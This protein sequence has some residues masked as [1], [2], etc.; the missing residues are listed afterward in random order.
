M[1]EL[2]SLSAAS[3]R[4]NG[5]D[6]HR[7]YDFIVCGAGSAGSVVAG[8]LAENP[9]VSVLLIEAGGTDEVPEVTTPGQ[10]PANLG[11]ARDWAFSAEPNQHLNG[12]RMALNMGKLLGGSSS[13]NVGVWARGHKNDWEHFAEASGDPGWRYESVLDIYKRVEDW[14][15]VRDPERRG[16]GGPIY[17]SPA[18]DPQPVAIAMLEAARGLGIPTFDSPNGAMMEGRGGAAI[19]DLLVKDG[20]RS[21]VFRS[22]VRPRMGQANLTV[23]TDTLVSRLT[24][25]GDAV[26]GV[27]VI[28]N[29][30]VT[31][32]EARHEV[33]VSM[34]AVNTP[35]LLMQSGIGPED[36]LRRHGIDIVQHLAGV[37]QN[38]QDHVAFGCIFECKAPQAVNYGGSEATL[39]WTSDAA[40]TLPDI[41]HCQLEFP[42]PSAET[43]SSAVPVNG[44]TMFAGLAHP[45]SRGSLHLTGCD[46]RDRI[47]IVANTLSHPDDI[48]AAFTTLELARELGSDAA[49]KDLVKGEALPGNLS[50]AAMEDYLRNAAMTFWHQAGTAK[51]GRDEMSVVDGELK[52]YGVDHLRIADASVMPNV[53]SG[54]T[55]APCV[56][57]GERCA[58]MIRASHGI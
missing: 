42:V 44:W 55:M 7:S 47:R 9:Q 56:V 18:Q 29:G 27:E 39:Y 30:R 49:F 3:A 6:H 32:Y 52:V 45:K 50:R 13:I 26:R 28:R 41:F 19:T 31:R 23:L 34:G 58:D 40:Q 5:G 17:V 48:A 43:A 16:E 21:S 35:K 53:T 10:W 37:G 2:F 20:Q 38:H 57:I 1:T 8:R 15:G 14:Q 4:G 11:S 46:A 22:Y 51:M 54:N 25:S 12:R 36:E 33:I 24:Y